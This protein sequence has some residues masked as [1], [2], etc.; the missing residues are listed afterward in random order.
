MNESSMKRATTQILTI[1]GGSSSIKF[2]L[3]QIGKPLER[4]LYGT[5][6]RIGMSGTN[7]SFNTPPNS[8]TQLRSK[9][10]RPQIGGD[11]LLDWLQEQQGF[12]S[13][14]ASRTPRGPWH[15]THRARVGHPGFA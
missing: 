2:A 4:G 6:D 12:A 1:N 8:R 15:A 11:A 14:Q 7:L 5:V 10:L 3:Y 13:V 9:P